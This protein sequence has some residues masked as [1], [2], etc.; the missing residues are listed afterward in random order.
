MSIYSALAFVLPEELQENIQKIRRNYD[1]AYDR[2]PPHINFFFPFISEYTIE[3]SEYKSEKSLIK[4]IS[5]ALVDIKPFKTVFDNISYFNFGKDKPITIWLGPQDPKPFE[6][7]FNVLRSLFPNLKVAITNLN[8][9]SLKVKSKNF[10]PHLTL[11]QKSYFQFRKCQERYKKEIGTIE[12][13]ID[14]IQILTRT[15]DTAFKP[16]WTIYFNGKEPVY[17]KK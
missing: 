5:E 7:T 8:N 3:Q 17:H 15:K 1:K 14:S 9:V 4:Q 2:W 10:T 13:T 11:A 16:L 12:C 6:E